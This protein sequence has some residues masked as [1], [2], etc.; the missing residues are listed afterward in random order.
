MSDLRVE[1][2]VNEEKR[3]DVRARIE[4]SNNLPTLPGVVAKIMEMV[5]SPQTTG[6]QLGEEIAKDQ[7]VSAKML[8]LVNSGFYG[9]SQPITTISH[10]VTML[11]FDAVKSLVMSSSVL[12]LMDSAMPGLWQHSLACARTCTM[13]AERI[14]QPN[15][16]EIGVI[17]LL[18]DLGKVILCQ[19]LEVDFERV[20]RRVEKL[21][22]LFVEAE[23]N[24]LGCHHGD[25]GGWLLEKWELPPKLLD[26]IVHHHDFQPDRDNAERTAIVHLSDILCRA[27]AFG[28]GGD[29]RIPMLDRRALETLGLEV[30]DVKYSWVE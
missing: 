13:V 21:D 3:N 8:K 25:I 17:G 29:R 22:L 12:E 16:E 26:P 28:N 15:P 10:A 4:E 19:T 30:A 18:H 5:D 23:V 2:S 27:E 11:G 9:F 20:R 14:D 24:A 1:R 6:R 7:V